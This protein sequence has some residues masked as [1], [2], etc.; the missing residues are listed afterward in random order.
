MAFLPNL[1][2]GANIGA[3]F[4][5]H[6]TIDAL[7]PEAQ[8]YLKMDKMLGLRS[9]IK[10]E[11]ESMVTVS[12]YYLIRQDLSADASYTE[13]SDD[14]EIVDT[15]DLE[16]SLKTQM[17]DLSWQRETAN[18][19]LMGEVKELRLYKYSNSTTNGHFGAS[20]LWHTRLGKKWS[21]EALKLHGFM[22][23]H[24]RSGYQLSDGLYTGVALGLKNDNPFG[25]TA[26]M[27]R[28][29]LTFMPH[30]NFKHLHVSY[31]LQTAFRNPQNDIWASSIHT[32][33]LSAPF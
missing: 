12:T 24:W 20:P 16:K 17:L 27:D 6:N 2:A 18:H 21:T 13:I 33:A 10:W 22:G 23:A 26:K 9:K 28:D 1:F 11:D 19:L 29:F 7:N 15:N 3:N 4:T 30:A 8:T 5:I 32:L 14:G 31:S 25:L